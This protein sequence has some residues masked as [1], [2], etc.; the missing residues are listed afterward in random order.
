MSIAALVSLLFGVGA[1]VD[2]LR[3]EVKPKGYADKG[4]ADD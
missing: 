2:Y 3:D 4:C 1:D